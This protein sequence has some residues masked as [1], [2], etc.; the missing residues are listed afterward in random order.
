MNAPNEKATSNAWIR[1]SA[2][3]RLTDAFTIS[4]C[5][6]ATVS[7]YRKTAL[8]MIH[9][10]GRKPY[11]APYRAVAVAVPT[12]IPYTI[13]DTAS[14][15]MIAASAARCARHSSTPSATSRRTIG[16]AA[17]AG[18]EPRISEGVVN[19]DPSL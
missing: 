8:R 17:A 11:A 4:N 7:W 1:R 16:K 9:P 13:V 15:E 19:L 5:P 18:T 14:A 10:M 2:D 6:V 3:R 12:G